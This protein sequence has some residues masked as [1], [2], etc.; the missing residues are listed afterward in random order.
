MLG[1]SALV[2]AASNPSDSRIFIYEVKGLRQNDN[3]DRNAYPLRSS[4]NVFI[5]VPYKK[6]NEEMRKINRMGGTIVSIKAMD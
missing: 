6:M 1:Q 4:D 5:K 3:N 2:N